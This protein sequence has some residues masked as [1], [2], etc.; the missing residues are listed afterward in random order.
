MF[1]TPQAADLSPPAT[2]PAMPASPKMCR[3]FHPLALLQSVHSH[4]LSMQSS[5][6]VLWLSAFSSSLVSL[7]APPLD[8]SS[9]LSIVEL[10]LYLM[11]G[12]PLCLFLFPLDLSVQYL[13]VVVWYPIMLVSTRRQS[14]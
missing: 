4:R 8:L 14:L 1:L 5:K 12:T 13:M 2:C 3:P 9:F 6:V 11:S 10:L 7:V